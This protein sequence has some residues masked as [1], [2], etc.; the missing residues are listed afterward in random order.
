MTTVYFVRHAQSDR[1]VHD[2]QT[3]PLTRKGFADT[4]EITKFFKGKNISK[5]FSSPMQR[6]IDTVSDFAKHARLE[7]QLVDD[8]KER[9]KDKWSE[10][11]LEI[12]QKSWEDFSLEIDG[13]SLNEVQARN[14][15]ALKKVLAGNR[16]GNIVI[17]THGTA[18]STILN[19]YDESFGLE[20]WKVMPMPWICRID[21]DENGSYIGWTGTPE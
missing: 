8:F 18:L 3:R 10:G 9:R 20:Q 11:H 4:L 12:I 6:A 21:F 1:G 19:Y 13:E 14:I 5:I 17:G 15:A 2:E 16:G 7:I